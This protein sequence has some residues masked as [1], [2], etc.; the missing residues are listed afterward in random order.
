MK[1]E[2]EKKRNQDIITKNFLYFSFLNK[3]YVF[4]IKY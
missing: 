4:T 1:K 3:L 2:I